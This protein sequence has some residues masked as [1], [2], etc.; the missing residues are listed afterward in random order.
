MKT[1]RKLSC[2]AINE[3]VDDQE[4]T[5][6]GKRIGEEEIDVDVIDP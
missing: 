2:K 6:H 3:E 5:N 1:E 4:M